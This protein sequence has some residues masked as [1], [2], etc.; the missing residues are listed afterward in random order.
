MSSTAITNI[1]KIVSG[2]V[3]RPLL[4]EDSVLVVDGKIEALNPDSSMI[5]NA[6]L[7]ID[8]S[9]MTLVPG[10]IDSHVHPVFG[11]FSP[12]LG[13]FNWIENY[14]EGG[15]T[16]M[17]SLGELHLPGRPSDPLGV[18]S[19]AILAA[20]SFR[21]SRPS[22]V[23]VL[24][25]TLILESGLKQ[26]DFRQAEEAG[27]QAVKFIRG[28]GDRSEAIRMSRWAKELGM[29]VIIH[30]GGTSLPDVPTTT[31]DQIF[32][33]EP[34]VL[35]HLNGG[36]TSLPAADIDRL[37]EQSN[38]IIDLVRFGNLKAALRIVE[39]VLS[40]HTPERIILGT[41][42]PTGSGMEPL[43]ILH[44]IT[45]LTSLSSLTP[46]VAI[47]MATG[48]TAQTYGLDSGRVNVGAL[49]DLALID[50][51]LGSAADNALDCISIGDV[52]AVAMVMIEGK[53]VVSP[54]KFTPPPQ[55]THRTIQLQLTSEL[56][57]P[58]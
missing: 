11:G 19:L 10:L 18:K 41:D 17:V 2:E 40:M 4:V 15:I 8:A 3:G 48:N 34:D 53:I 37:I 32:E 52:P 23:K 42:S 55:N 46:D 25:G 36:P 57:F 12:R 6:G 29:K 49:A 39:A 24:A 44:L 13:V 7:V 38:W 5:A 16:S 45:T 54:S 26:V 30:C 21:N 47:C 14:L 51:P 20:K 35:A 58:Q 50:A 43:G 56:D 27:V 33:I 22:G 31:A 1:G 9:G 28:I